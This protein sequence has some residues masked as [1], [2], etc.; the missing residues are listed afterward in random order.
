MHIWNPKTLETLDDA[1]WFRYETFYYLCEFKVFRHEER[2]TQFL[3]MLTFPS[4]SHHVRPLLQTTGLA[5]ASSENWLASSIPKSQLSVFFFSKSPKSSALPG[6][7]SFLSPV[8]F[9]IWG[10]YCDISDCRIH[11]ARAWTPALG[12]CT[13]LTHA[14]S[15]R[16]SALLN[17]KA[18]YTKGKLII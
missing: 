18:R 9:L 2:D 10:F 5:S 12:V 13:Q 8:P 1:L 17:R 7:T 11:P 4:D 15:E 3:S 6:M 16:L 14:P